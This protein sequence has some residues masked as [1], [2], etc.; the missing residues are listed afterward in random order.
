MCEALRVLRVDPWQAAILPGDV[1]LQA[2]LGA[3]AAARRRK[4]A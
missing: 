3:R 1:L 4:S 2:G